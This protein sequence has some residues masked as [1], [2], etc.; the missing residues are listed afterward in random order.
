MSTVTVL[1]SLRDRSLQDFGQIFEQHYDL[2]Y[3]TA[4]SITRQAEDAEDVAQS[5]FLRLLRQE[6]APD[7]TKNPRGY[8]YRAAVNASLKMI[9]QRDRCILTGESEQVEA[10]KEIE[11]SSDEEMDQLLWKAIAELNEGAAQILILRYVHA[12]SLAD[13]AKLLGT[14]RSAI[15]VNLFRSR[16]RLKKLIRASQ[17]EQL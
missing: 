9:R 14:S 7:L 2:V 11:N 10:A 16:A 6:S 4:Y 17:G 15:A 5:I 3:R 13:I 12:Y 1:D 8:F